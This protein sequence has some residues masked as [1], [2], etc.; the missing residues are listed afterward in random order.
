MFG[1]QDFVSDFLSFIEL[2]EARLLSWGFYDVSLDIDELEELF[3]M[4]A[5]P[6]LKERWAK[7]RHNWPDLSALCDDLAHSGL[8]YRPDSETFRSRFAE[9]VRL[10]ARLRQMFQPKDWATGA[11]LISDVR[12]HLEPRCYPKRDQSPEECWLEI[13]SACRKTELQKAAFRALS[14]DNRGRRYE[15]FSGFQRKAF[16]HILEQYSAKGVKGSV[17]AAGTGS[18]KTKAFYIPAFLGAITELDL[19]NFTKIVAIYPRNV[20]L[21]DQLREAL[22]EAE[23]LRPVLLKSGL[24]P[25]TFGALLGDTPYQSWFKPDANGNYPSHIYGWKRVHN[26]FVVPFLKS[27]KTPSEDLVWRDTDRLAGRTCLYQA[28]GVATEPDVPDN[29][30]SLTREQLMGTPPDVLFLSLEMLNREMGNPAWSRA[31]GMARGRLCPRLLLLDEVH[32]YEGLRGA[33]AAWVLR[34]WRHWSASRN[35]QMVGLSATL[36]DGPQHLSTVTGIPAS[37]VVEFRPRRDELTAEGMEYNL[38]VKGDPAS[39]ASLLAT[40]IQCGMLLARLLVPR[41]IPSSGG[42]GAIRGDWFHGRKVFG[43]TDNLDGLNRWF[44]DMVDADRNRRLA[45][46]R[47]HPRYRNPPLSLPAAELVQM[48]RQGQIWELPRRLGYNL[49]QPLM[50]SRCSSQD[51]GANAGSDLIIATSSLEVGYD[52]PEVGAVLHHKRPASLSSFIQRKGRAGRRRGVRPWTVVVLSDYGGD[53]WAFQQPERLFQPEIESIFLPVTN[54]FVLRVQATYFLVDWLGRKINTGSPFSY[55]RG[56]GPYYRAT[57]EAVRILSDFLKQG[58]EWQKFHR[59]FASFFSLPLGRGGRSL[60]EM[61]VEAIFWNEPRPLLTSVVPTLLRKLEAGFTLGD[62]EKTGSIE[63]K[64]TK[65]PLP[66]FLPSATFAELGISESVLEF[67]GVEGK[68]PEIMSVAKVLSEACP[69]RVSKRFSVGLEEKGYWHHFSENLLSAVTAASVDELF[70][71]SLFLETLDGM[72]VYQPQSVQLVPIPKNIV[73]SSHASWL[74]RTVFRSMGSG[75]ELPIF[76]DWKSECFFGKCQA[77]LH[78]DQSGLE[79]LRYAE[80]CSF[81]IRQRKR[82]PVTGRFHLRSLADGDPVREAVGFRQQVDGIAVSLNP[83]CLEKVPKIGP[84]DVSRFRAEYFLDLVRN[85]ERFTDQPFMA[86]W[87]WRTSLAMLSATAL[88][89]A[90]TLEKAQTMLQ[91]GR[92]QAVERV[93][94]LIFQVRSAGSEQDLDFRLKTKI[95]EL[96]NDSSV[97]RHMGELEKCLWTDQGI[98]F[99]EWLRHRFAATLAQAFRTAAVSRLDEVS[100]DDLMIDLLWSDDGRVSIYLTEASSGG[101]GQIEMVVH[102]LMQHPDRFHEAF[103]YALSYC[104]REYI[105]KNLIQT[106]GYAVSD[107]SSSLHAAFGQVR[108]VSGFRAQEAARDALRLE[109]ENSGMPG[110]RT[111]VVSILTR[112]LGYGTSEETDGMTHLLNK[113]IKR[114]STRL[115]LSLDPRVFA[116]L[117]VNYPPAR[118]RL[119]RILENIGGTTPESGQIYAVLQHFLL[120]GC[121]DS[122]PECLDHPNRFNDFGRPSRTL[123]EIW[124]GRKTPTVSSDAEGWER[125][126]ISVLEKHGR[127]AV[128]ADVSSIARVAKTIQAFLAEEMEV[129]YLLLP[130]SITSVK[131]NGAE[132]RITLEVKESAYDQ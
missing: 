126:A 102:E 18:G 92:R 80:T 16:R 66:N 115:G 25:L 27:P 83:A 94:D 72:A 119:A 3:E 33:Q 20:L 48:D 124:L 5:P 91:N 38:L 56:P 47:L 29:A 10:L 2:R 4:E 109:L 12:L 49:S 130:I 106:L 110:S 41:Y 13:E 40:S 132:W 122:C 23:K 37:S 112:L 95:I 97:C 58:P 61:D 62:P 73:E 15:G 108:E 32:S 35:L 87:L 107:K 42:E 57:K 22:S 113:A 90:C 30:L 52:D 86:E 65:H 118:R 69:G 78:R 9:G 36:K 120:A 127:V 7:L 53:R 43:F 63:D 125:S 104:P 131:R 21:A 96:W 111:L 82:D 116:Y 99:I 46:L 123:A 74:W 28:S 55:L 34:R 14:A 70:P 117:C 114:H 24:R 59:D 31:F 89:N 75:L 88:S 17:I 44:S 67:S 1:L 71:Q 93:L 19:E 39:G 85:S 79:V 81:E 103:R 8:L 121:Q 45:R 51:P 98:G 100:E 105:S 101:L 68:D 60:S 6:E 64:G 129:D 77:H 26:G 84:E 76:K 50:V 128:T 54:P 11:N